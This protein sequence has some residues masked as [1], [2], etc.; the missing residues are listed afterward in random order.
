MTSQMP[1]GGA[2]AVG[3]RGTCWP[4]S[5]GGAGPA[6][7]CASGAVMRAQC[8][9]RRLRA[10]WRAKLVEEELL[11]HAAV[12]KCKAVARESLMKDAQKLRAERTAARK[13][14]LKQEKHLVAQLEEQLQAETEEM[15]V[16]RQEKQHLQEEREELELE[17]A[18]QQHQLE[19]EAAHVPGAVLPKLVEAELEK[20]EQ[21]RRRGLA[22]WMKTICLIFVS[23]LLLLV[24]VLGS[25]VLYAQHYDQELLYRLLLR[26]LPQ[27][28]YAS[29]AYFASRSLRVVCDGL[30]PI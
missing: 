17:G 14:K 11:A 24:A 27:A 13:E 25:A 6:R 29:P 21:A 23:L 4:H 9:S 15:E 5:A 2:G 30:L 18:W 28:M 12:E 1:W 10:V 7:S 22:F 16:L 3:Q 8:V 20:K 26:V 19:L